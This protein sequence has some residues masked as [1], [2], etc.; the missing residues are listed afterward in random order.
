MAQRPVSIV[1]ATTVR[2]AWN[3]LASAKESTSIAIMRLRQ[4]EKSIEY[5]FIEC[6][7]GQNTQ[8]YIKVW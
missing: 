8:V 6:W 3:G 4:A 2:G 5:R 7:L 1:F